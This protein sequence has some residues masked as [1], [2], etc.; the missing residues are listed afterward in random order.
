MEIDQ[1]QTI[2][3]RNKDKQREMISEPSEIREQIQSKQHSNNLKEINTR[4]II[5]LNNSAI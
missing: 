3:E 4:L 5:Q 2:E 1:A